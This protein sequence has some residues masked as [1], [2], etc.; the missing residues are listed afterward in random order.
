MEE[1]VKTFLRL[2]GR[3]Y[4]GILAALFLFSTVPGYAQYF[5]QNKVQYE[6]FEFKVMKTEHFDIY[7]YPEEEE[8]I[9]IA[10]RMAERWNARLSRMLNHKLRGRQPLIMYASS[11]HFQQTTAISG[12]LG[13]GTGGVTELFKRRVVLPFGASLAETDHVIGH[14]LVHAFQF[15]ITSRGPAGSAATQSTAMMLPLWLIEGLAEYLSIGAVDPHTAMWMREATRQ[16]DL[17]TIKKMANYYKYF[18]YRFGQSLWAFMTGKWGDD[19]VETLLKAAGRSG[20]Y[21]A[22]IESVLK[23]K[24]AQLSKQWHEAMKKVYSP[25]LD[26]TQAA[27][28]Q[29]EILFKGSKKNPLNIA[30]SIS[31]DGRHM[32]FLSTKDLFSIDM[33]IADAETGKIQR[34]LVKTAVDPHFESIQ[35][36]KSAGSWDRES[37]HFVF[38]GIAKGRPILVITDVERGKHIKE[39]DFPELDEILSPA[40]APDGGA[41]IFSAMKGGLSDLYH[42]DLE[43]E[44]LTNLTND[45]YGDLY[46]VWSPDGK[47]VAFATERFSSDM[48]R[49]DTGNYDLALYSPENGKITR[50]PGFTGVKNINP[51]WS[52]DSR[53]LYFISDKN[54]ISN[55]FKMDV[56][57][58]EILQVTNLYSGVTGITSLS[59]A[60]SL[61]QDTKKLAFTVYEEGNYNIYTLDES[62]AESLE[63]TDFGEVR[64]DVLPPR[65]KPEGEVLGLLRNPYYG[66]PQDSNYTIEDYNPKLKLD[67]I[68]QPSV[69]VG[70]DR[71]GSYVGGGLAMFFSDMMGYHTLVGMASTSQRLMD[72]TFLVGYQNAKNRINW[73]A[74][75]QRIPYVYGGYYQYYDTVGGIPA[76]VEE[77]QLFRQI[78]YEA[79][80]FASYPFSKAQRFELGA[81]YRLLDFSNVVYRNYYGAADGIGMGREKIKLPSAPSLSFGF[82]NAALVYDTS[83]FGL[84]APILGRSYRIEVSPYR[85]SINFTNVIADFRKYFIPVKPFTLAFR[86]LHFGRYGAGAEDSRLYPMFLGYETLVRGYSYESYSQD[87]VGLNPD[88]F[89]RLFGSRIAVA[90][91]ELRFP[92]FGVL[93]IGKGYYGIFP[94]DFNVF[95][96]AGVAWDSNNQLWF[97]GGLRKPVTSAGVGVRVNLFGYLVI[98]VNY[99]KPFN[100][101]RS[102]YFQFTF[103]PGF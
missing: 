67:Y 57:L 50:L 75:V 101:D 70:V 5:G 21:E 51:Q 76:I 98:G 43:K 64:P 63:V 37:K 8:G 47:A 4:I 35:F 34:K 15:D 78:N 81:G 95:F 60:L 65:E 46:P 88:S 97:Q 73:G 42:Y 39:I 68:S 45:P 48:L 71:F 38:S 53:Y 18:P 11:P 40:W 89:D 23:I 55:I 72:S 91:V 93:G 59:P 32:V 82:A 84:T 77:E 25:L 24:P 30:P 83:L 6:D 102:P 86:I 49:L 16:E 52:S 96:D 92:L 58:G 44:I 90:N 103:M 79:S 85:G 36:I 7:Y 62:R 22:A 33:F 14:E 10:A 2:N 61:A 1:K 87:E 41:L 80:C 56:A 31:P 12:S 28:K 99:V 66:L 69:A 100:R 13:E 9:R 54:G 19:V 26:R 20:S 17:P 27:S 94:V 29:A 74:V 3:L